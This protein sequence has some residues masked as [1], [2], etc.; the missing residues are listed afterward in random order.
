MKNKISKGWL[1][2][3]VVLSVS[4]IIQV[5]LF[6]GIVPAHLT[7][8]Y[9]FTPALVAFVC[10]TDIHPFI[11]LNVHPDTH[12]YAHL[13]LWRGIWMARVPLARINEDI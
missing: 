6:S 11:S 3:L 2:I 12:H 7:G 5:L 8:L 13:S 1:C 10:F 4:L 9:M